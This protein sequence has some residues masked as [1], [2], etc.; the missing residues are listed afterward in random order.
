MC[1]T[2]AIIVLHGMQQLREIN[3]TTSVFILFAVHILITFWYCCKVSKIVY[4]YLGSQLTSCL[5]LLQNFISVDGILFTNVP[6]K[7][8]PIAY[9]EYLIMNCW[10]KYPLYNCG[11]ITSHERSEQRMVEQR[12]K[13]IEGRVVCQA[14]AR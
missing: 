4:D 2:I 10:W 1:C 8:N 12:I 5:Q 6:S 3:L 13:A 11:L 9:K 14:K 7:L